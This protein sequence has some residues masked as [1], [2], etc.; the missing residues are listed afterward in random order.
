MV[1][2]FAINKKYAVSVVV[3]FLVSIVIGIGC[4]NAA[5]TNEELMH[6]HYAGRVLT[7]INNYPP[8][9]GTDVWA[10][11]FINHLGRHI[12]GN[13]TIVM[14]HRGGAAGVVGQRYLAEVRRPDGYSLG[15]LGGNMVSSQA[16]LTKDIPDT[17]DHRIL[18]IIAG[19]GD[20]TLTAGHTSVFPE[21]GRSV[22]PGMDK[23]YFG[24]QERDA[25]LVRSFAQFEMLGLE[26]G[27]E[28]QFIYGYSSGSAVQLAIE[29][30]EVSAIFIAVAPFMGQFTENMVEP[31]M[32]VALWQ[33]GLE[34]AA[35]LIR[36]PAIPEIPT[37]DEVY[38]EATGRA[39]SGEGYDF[40]RWRNKG[41]A[42]MRTLVFPPGTPDF[43][44]E[45]MRTAVANML[46]D[47][48]YLDDQERIFGTREPLAIVGADAEAIIHEVIDG[49]ERF[50]T[51][52][53]EV[54]EIVQ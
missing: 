19:F 41:N 36:H 53:D 15:A 6:A 23:W 29:Q 17:A 26:H 43:I 13:P 51:Y 30:Q 37:F 39:P 40:K 52:I 32:G 24:I 7:L 12:P 22:V 9:G 54:F 3:V 42:V 48:L 38:Y 10:S 16:T 44:I 25:T 5:Q 4:A 14:E 21:A 27:R 46:D 20:V 33:D 49:A 8:G 31:G 47:P 18:G 34:T 11:T 28:Y 35:G 2:Q 50:M 1:S 45:G